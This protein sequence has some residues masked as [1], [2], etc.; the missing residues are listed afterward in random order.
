MP[1]KSAARTLVCSHLCIEIIDY[2]VPSS[3]DQ[4]FQKQQFNIALSGALAG[5]AARD[6]IVLEFLGE[7]AAVFLGDPE[8]ALKVALRVR[9]ALREP[10]TSDRPAPSVR[11]GIN[12]GPI[13]LI[14]DI[15][16]QL[17]VIGDGLI[18]ARTITKFAKSQQIL[19]SRSF[20]DVVVLLFERLAGLFDYQGIR[21]DQDQREH[22]EV[23][24]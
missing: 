2:A 15:N 11:F 1:S 24:S 5:I 16:E 13:R 19:V 8:D 22:E 23:G 12:H 18:V 7:T 6:R 17:N 9:G 10:A 14:R 4:L 3:A 20:H 21:I